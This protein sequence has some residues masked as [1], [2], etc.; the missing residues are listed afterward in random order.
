MQERDAGLPAVYLVDIDG[1]VA[2]FNGR[3]PYYESRVSS[4][5]L[6]EPVAEVLKSLLA[7]GEKL[8]FITGRTDAS[9]SDTAQWLARH[10]LENLAIHHR[11]GGDGRQD[12]VVKRELFEQHIRGQFRVK[13]VF[14]DRQQVVD[15]WREL[16]LTVFQVA[17]GNF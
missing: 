1:T 2:L 7:T 6:N 5:L 12:A 3:N 8:I 15:M 11:A 13:A 16:G 4:D 10:G 14:D 17:P 9:A